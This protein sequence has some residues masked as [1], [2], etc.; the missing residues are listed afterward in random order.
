M[1]FLILS[2][3]LYTANKVV[4]IKRKSVA[5]DME[6]SNSQKVL[7]VV[8]GTVKQAVSNQVPVLKA[9]N[10]KMGSAKSWPK[11]D[12]CAR[13]SVSGWDWRN[14]SLKASPTHRASVRG[15]SSIGS[16]TINI[17]GII[18]QLSNCKGLSARTNRVKLRNLLAAAEGADLLKAS[19]L[20]V[21]NKVF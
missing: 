15:S 1:P 9:K 18:P 3:D 8:K 6:Q 13:C 7:K 12:G 20:K 2:L 19:Q 14:W 17:D 16:Q 10:R 4:K 21:A 11:S 5:D